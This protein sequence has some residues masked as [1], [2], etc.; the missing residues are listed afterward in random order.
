MKP[1]LLEL[2]QVR[3]N[4]RLLYDMAAIDNAISSVARA[5]TERYHDRN[6]LLLTVMNGGVVFAGRLLTELPFPLE[7]DYLH[8]TRYAGETT[9]NTE[10]Q[11]L[12]TPGTRLAG[13]DVIVLDDI[14][15]VGA[16]LL[17]IVE[18]C[19]AQ[20]AASVATAV[21]VDKVHSRKA[22]PGLKADFTG[23]ETEDAYLFGCGMDYKGFWRNA[24]G[25]F[26]VQEQ[27]EITS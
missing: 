9:G 27:G 13:R 17:A 21:L 3:E 12:V 15:D 14:L 22:Q 8:A 5:I 16:T 6:P 19:R 10:I 2:A 23:V 7:I 24:P 26:A 4:A 1:S 20:G 11:W 18:A 25:I